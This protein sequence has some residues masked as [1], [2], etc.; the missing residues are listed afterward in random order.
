MR[1]N[2][3]DGEP[4]E[5]NPLGGGADIEARRILAYGMRNPFRFELRPGTDELYIGDVGWETW[6]EL[7]RTSSP[8]APGQPPANFGWPCYEGFGR[9]ADWQLL[10]QEGQAPLCESLYAP[11][12]TN[13]V[14]PVFAYVH[15]EAQGLFRRHLSFGIGLIDL[16]AG[17][18]RAPGLAVGE[19]IP[20]IP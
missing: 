6:E 15:S 11:G 8:P 1:I 7:D 14:P 9:Q 17:V 3:F 16:G 10:A 18:L 20:R 12:D 19:R 2:R 4:A 5:G 13:V